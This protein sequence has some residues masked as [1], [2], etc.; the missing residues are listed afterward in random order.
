MLVGSK[1]DLEDERQVPID[2]GRQLA[3][4]FQCSFMEVSAKANINVKEAFCELVKL[5]NMWREQHPLKGSTAANKRDCCLL[6]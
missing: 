2:D 5:I 1:C 4:K 6:V 3:A